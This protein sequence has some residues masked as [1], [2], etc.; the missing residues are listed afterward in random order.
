MAFFAAAFAPGANSTN[1]RDFSAPTRV[2]VITRQKNVMAAVL[3][4]WM[5]AFIILLERRLM[6]AQRHPQ[7]MPKRVHSRIGTTPRAKNNSGGGL[8]FL[9]CASGRC[10]LAIRKFG[11]RRF[12]CAL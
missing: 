7:V 4:K 3:I 9:R 1:T 5:V 8:V 10:L 12:V 6:R 11:L 2:E